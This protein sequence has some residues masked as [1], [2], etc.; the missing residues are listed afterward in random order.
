MLSR[1]MLLTGSL[2]QLPVTD[3]LQTAEAGRRSGTVVLRQGERSGTLWMRGGRI[4]DAEIAGGPRG[5]DAV[6][7]IAVWEDGTFAAD[8]TPV[9]VPERIFEPTSGLLLEAMRRRDE[10][11]AQIPRM[12]LHAAIPDP[13]PSPPR[14]LLAV[15]RALTLT[16]VASSYALQ[17]LEPALLARRLEECRQGLLLAHPELVVFQVSPEGAVAATAAPADDAEAEAL[18][19]ATARWLARLFEQLERALPGRF[20]LERLRAVT[21]AVQDDL[22][23]LGFYRELGLTVGADGSADLAGDAP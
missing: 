12:P 19:R 14:R 3:L 6:Y 10:A 20:S 1:P 8:F 5:A 18:V 16:N 15:H 11:M 21:E 17:F 7:E 9:T 23:V 2:A 4:V 13:P 22:A